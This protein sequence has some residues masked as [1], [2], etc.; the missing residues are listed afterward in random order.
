MDLDLFELLRP[1][2]YRYN[3]QPVED[4]RYHKGLI[5]QEVAELFP[6]CVEKDAL[7]YDEDGTPYLKEMDLLGLDMMGLIT[8]CIG[9][10][11]AMREE[12]SDLRDELQNAL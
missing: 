2:K 4:T 5:A 11:K 8:T 12:I 7:A 9:A 1:V 6:D 3:S 10:I